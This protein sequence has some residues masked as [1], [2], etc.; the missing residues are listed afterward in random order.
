MPSFCEVP[1]ES[2][3]DVGQ[4]APQ[5]DSLEE[6]VS[7]RGQQPDPTEPSGAM[8]KLPIQSSSK[9]WGSETP[10][11]QGVTE[12]DSKAEADKPT[13]MAEMRPR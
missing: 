2:G 13:V 3:D 9:D 4:G 1:F 12:A 6:P 8:R 10:Q 7:D 11:L 5:L